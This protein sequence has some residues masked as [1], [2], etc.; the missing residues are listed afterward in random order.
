M[1]AGGL[2]NRTRFTV[3]SRKYDLSLRRSWTAYLLDKAEDH[4]LLEG[5]FEADISHPD[6]GLISRGTRSVEAFIPDRWYNYFIF[7][8]PHG[9]LRNYYINISLPPV[10]GHGVVDYFDLDIDV[11]IW[12][13]QRLE[14]LDLE[15]FGVNATV[16][17]YPFEVI[18]TAV[19][20]K[21]K[22]VADPYRFI[23]RIAA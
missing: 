6:L 16:Y 19:D 20:L 13:D 4:I 8:E 21:D 22:I 5:F 7:Y 14:V 11:I 15:E 2:L 23:N 9:G 18:Q 10:I 17:Q 1:P 3:N 12:P